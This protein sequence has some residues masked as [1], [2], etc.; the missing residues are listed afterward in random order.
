MK[1]QIL[2]LMLACT[3][4]A[5][6]QPTSNTEQQ[7]TPVI[8]AEQKPSHT[9]VTP[10]ASQQS[11]N[12]PQAEQAPIITPEPKDLDL[13]IRKGDLILD[14]TPAVTRKSVLPNLFETK[15]PEKKR[16]SVGGKLLLDDQPNVE[17]RE[18]VQGAQMSIQV[19]TP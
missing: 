15:K 10:K 5:C 19:S 13:N 17:L 9:R 12:D 7:A 1:K 18:S 8:K 11:A 3:L 6:E 16:L 2:L 4:T 14:D